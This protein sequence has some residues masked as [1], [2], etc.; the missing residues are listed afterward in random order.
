MDEI[1]PDQI[2]RLRSK[3]IDTLDALAALEPS[4][5]RAL[6]GIEG[7]RLLGH[8]RGDLPE[9][10]PESPRRPG[11]LGLLAN[12]LSGRLERERLLARGL[13]LSVEYADGIRRERHGRL[14][15]PTSAAE[16]L[17]KAAVR[18]FGRLRST[19]EPVVGVSLTATGLLSSEQ[20]DLFGSAGA[21]DLRVALGRVDREAPAH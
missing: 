21:R 17:E 9:L 12:R 20:I 11:S 19:A 14:P 3:G 1:R 7:E 8:V 2:S 4:E 10:V 5:A 15:R 16:E 13:E 18:L 6:L